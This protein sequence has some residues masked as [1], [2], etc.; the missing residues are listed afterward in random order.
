LARRT[1][2]KKRAEGG[3]LG[4]REKATR[5][6]TRSSF[7]QKGAFQSVG[8]AI[9]RVRKSRKLIIH[10][11]LREGKEKGLA[12]KEKFSKSWCSGRGA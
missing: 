12:G 1:D 6:K 8:K 9:A 5:L 2:G 4:A 11:K 10:K 3:F 7:L